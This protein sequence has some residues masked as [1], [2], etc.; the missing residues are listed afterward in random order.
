MGTFDIKYNWQNNKQISFDKNITG[1]IK[2]IFIVTQNTL[3]NIAGT[4]IIIQNTTDWIDILQ[5][6]KN[7]IIKLI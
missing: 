2:N 4:F 1:N 3:H 6:E 5:Y 7:P